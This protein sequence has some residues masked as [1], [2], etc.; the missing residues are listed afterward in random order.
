VTQ[1]D[2][3]ASLT[4][5]IRAAG[6]RLGDRL[7][8]EILA[9]LALEKPRRWLYAHGESVPD[10]ATAA[11]FEALLHARLNGVPIAY[12]SGQRE[13]HGRN[14]RVDRRVLIPRPETEHLVDFA[15]Q[16]DLP[17][18]AR[19]ADVGTG[20]GCII[21]SLACERPRWRCIGCD[22]STEALQVA[23]INRS[24]L[25]ADNVVLVH[26]DLLQ[27]LKGRCFE[28][29]VANPPY[30]AEGDPHLDRGDLRHEPA[31]ALT[32]G[33]DGLDVL[34]RLAT[35]APGLLQ[36]AGWLAVEHGHDQA[37]Q[38][39]AMFVAAGLQ[40]IAS[41]RDLGGIERITAGQKPGPE[42]MQQTEAEVSPVCPA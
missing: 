5:R 22:L 36:A 31:I 13:F 30:V 6:E 29:I 19:V 21:L 23:E 27:P 16:L 1:S 24:Q 4:S 14:F 35:E 37:Q 8:A 41:I 11:R 9:A 3:A 38:V 42:T 15:L 40:N 26:G 2:Q 34:R 28:L 25:A 32:P 10:P 12:L 18:Q 17:D 7:E 33:G 20:S 39:R